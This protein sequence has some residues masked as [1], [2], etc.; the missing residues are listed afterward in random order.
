MKALGEE[1]FGIYL[2]DLSQDTVS[3]V[4]AAE[5][6]EELV[7]GRRK[8]WN[9]VL[10]NL[11]KYR[12][13]PDYWDKFR[14]MFS[15]EVLQ[16]SSREGKTKLELVAERKISGEY[17]Y[18]SATAHFYNYGKTSD[19]VVMAFQDVDARIR[20]EIERA[21]NDIRMAAI[22]QSRYGVM[23]TLHLSSGICERVYLHGT[24]RNG[25]TEKGDYAAY[26]E[27]AVENCVR[28]ED[29]ERFLAVFSLE[30]LRKKAEEVEDFE[31][32]IFQYQQKK[33]AV[34][35]A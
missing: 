21:Q 18:I 6:D 4:R 15:R 27:K 28:D 23:N 30:N 13:H 22:I 16:E 26:I 14:S 10:E 20:S 33:G 29:R 3:A 9:I 8:G 1:N 19:Y 2:I 31:E 25:R 11:L 7:G 24:E 12:Y 32:I 35:V 34:Q 17:H 5:E